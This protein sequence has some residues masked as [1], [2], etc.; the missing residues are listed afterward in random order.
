MRSTPQNDRR[1]LLKGLVA[2]GLSHRLAIAGSDSNPDVVIIGAGIA[3]L[4]AARTLAEQKITF[5]L[6]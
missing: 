3:G 2:L 6:I 5:T 1:R 4:E